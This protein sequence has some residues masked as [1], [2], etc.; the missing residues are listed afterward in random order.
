MK[1]LFLIRHAKSS[2]ENLNLDDFDRPLNKRGEKDA[3]FM[4][5][6]LKEKNIIPDLIIS[7]PA[8]RTKLTAEI[9]AEKIGF[10]DKISFD[11]T[12]YE[13]PLCNLK[14][15]VHNIDDSFNTIF[16]VGHNPGLCDLANFLCDIEIENIPTCAI[17]EID[18]DSKSW[19]DISK[20]NSTLISFESPKKYK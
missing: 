19:K 9:I 13:A 3:P 18:F 15:V 20:D 10:I 2:W 17:L 5:E 16:F 11:K 1:K 6:I 12:I 8:L 14:K 4:A 7:S